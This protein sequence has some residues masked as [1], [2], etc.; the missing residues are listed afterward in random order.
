[1]EL[2][3]DAKAI[4][5]LTGELGMKKGPAGIDPLTPAQWKH[6]RTHLEANNKRP[7]DLFHE[8]EIVREVHWGRCRSKPSEETIEKLLD[9]D[10]E[11]ILEMAMQRWAASNLWVLTY[12]DDDYPW[13]LKMRLS[14]HSDFP[15]LIFG[16]GNQLLLQQGGLAVVGSRRPPEDF[17]PEKFKEYYLGYARSLGSAAAE[18]EVT[19]ISGAA[20]GVDINAMRSSLESGGKVIGVLTHQ[21]LAKTTDNSFWKC[22]QKIQD[23]ILDGKIVLMSVT[24]P[25]KELHG[26]YYGRSAMQRNKYIY[27][28]SDAAVVVRSDEKGGT[29]KGAEE[30]LENF[31]VPLWVFKQD[32]DDIKAGNEKIEGMKEIEKKKGDVVTKRIAI[33]KKARGLPEDMGVSDHLRSALEERDIRKAVILLTVNLSSD[34]SDQVEPLD[35]KEWGEFAKFLRGKE[36]TPADLL[37]KPFHE[38]LNDGGQPYLRIKQIEGLLNPGRINRLS[39]EEKSWWNAGVFIF[40]RQ[41]K[42]YYPKTLITKLWDNSPAIVFVS[43]NSELLASARKKIAILG[44]E[45]NDGKTDL[46]H[47]HSLGTA[48]AQREIVVVST[49]NTKIEEEALKGALESGGKCIVVLSGELQNFLLN[50]GY[51]KHFE[52]QQLVLLSAS[53]PHSEPSDMTSKQ[54][55][56]IACA[57]S[58]EVIVVRSE[59]NDLIVNCVKNR[60]ERGN[61]PIWVWESEE[62]ILG[63]KLIVEQGDG[64]WLPLGMDADRHVRYIL[65]SELNPVRF[66]Q[67]NQGL[68]VDRVDPLQGR[69]LEIV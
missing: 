1:M 12:L 29:W 2:P 31:W 35:Y 53:A 19:I 51:H 11:S 62:E 23:Y 17:S 14:N 24:D 10:R 69:Q 15:S 22:E 65:D 49:N 32:K 9:R 52:D 27:C 38:I 48:L 13:R 39:Q 60:R 16:V 33:A 34:Q 63:N 4:L 41:D 26:R 44:S 18:E 50:S 7:Q 40:T 67:Q 57:L 37:H 28:L 42:G 6:L 46:C 55:Y 59:T 20:R 58:T 25:E 36:E 56:E 54:H 45:P 3:N 64:Y 43:G 5:L 47:A 66:K 8:K 30:N 21:L 68:Q 61:S